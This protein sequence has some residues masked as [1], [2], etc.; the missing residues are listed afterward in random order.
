MCHCICILGG[1]YLSRKIQLPGIAYPV[2]GKLFQVQ[3]VFRQTTLLRGRGYE[4]GQTMALT[5]VLC[6]Y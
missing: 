6:I 4:A 3:K 5:H 1:E 2:E